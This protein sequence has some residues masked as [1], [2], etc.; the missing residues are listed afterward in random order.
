MREIESSALPGVT[1]DPSLSFEDAFTRLEMIIAT[2]R[3]GSATLDEALAYY[4]E[5]VKLARYCHQLLE[6]AELRVKQ[7]TIDENGYLRAEPFTG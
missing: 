3:D 2:L 5:G 4:E 1:V 6:N 7:L